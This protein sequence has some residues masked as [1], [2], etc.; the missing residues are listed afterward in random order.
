MA[1]KYYDHNKIKAYIEVSRNDR[2]RDA[3]YA[4]DYQREYGVCDLITFT[5]HNRN[6]R[7]II[8]SGFRVG[9]DFIFHPLFSQDGYTAYKITVEQYNQLVSE[10]AVIR[11][12]YQSNPVSIFVVEKISAMSREYHKLPIAQPS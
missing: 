6:G 7:K 3:I 10:A 1:E 11:A 8:I 2:M 5:T 4:N 9:N 12:R